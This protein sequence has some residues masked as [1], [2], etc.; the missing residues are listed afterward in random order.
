M[1]ANLQFPDTLESVIRTKGVCP[2]MQS[3]ILKFS[4]KLIK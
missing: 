3:E 4:K 2:K 1:K